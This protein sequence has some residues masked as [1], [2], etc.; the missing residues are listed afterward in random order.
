MYDFLRRHYPHQVKG[1]SWITSSQP[2]YTSSPVFIFYMIHPFDSKH[3]CFFHTNQLYNEERL[4]NEL[5]AQY[6]GIRHSVHISKPQHSGSSHNKC[7]AKL[8]KS[9][10]FGVNTGT[11]KET[12]MDMFVS[13][14]VSVMVAEAGLE[15]TTSGL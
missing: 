3:K 15:P 6:V 14:T 8:G 12:V 2:A 9:P 5:K 11:K 7:V 1:R 13:I 10:C 4:F